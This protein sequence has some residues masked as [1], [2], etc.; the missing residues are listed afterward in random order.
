MGPNPINEI[1]GANY[2]LDDGSSVTPA[3]GTVDFNITVTAYDSAND[4]YDATVTKTN[5]E[6]YTAA[7][8]DGSM[9]LA[10]RRTW[11]YSH[12]EIG[13]CYA[14]TDRRHSDDRR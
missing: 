5:P 14:D 7:Y 2:V 4:A 8:V 9:I 1:G 6:V 11:S 3:S 10:S 13:I 12:S